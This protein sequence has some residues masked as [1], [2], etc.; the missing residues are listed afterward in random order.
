MF[1]EIPKEVLDRVSIKEDYTDNYF[2]DKY[3]GLPIYG[4]SDFFKTL[5]K[6]LENNFKF[7]LEEKEFI[8]E[9]LI[10]KLQSFKYDFIISTCRP[11]LLFLN[12][13]ILSYIFTRFSFTEER[14]Y[15][16]L[17]P[18]ED[19]CVTNF[20]VNF[21]FTRI[22]DFKNMYRHLDLN[23]TFCLEYPLLENEFNCRGFPV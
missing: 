8:K 16:K 12:K 18:D 9:D 14:F 1:S 20:P 17:F 5:I 19:S 4:Y 7:K 21:D 13:S 2:N 6:Y 22:T 23:P 15:K 11:D 10:V 3:Q